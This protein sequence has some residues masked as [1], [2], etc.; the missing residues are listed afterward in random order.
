ML[1]SDL[2]ILAFI[3]ALETL[4]FLSLP[5]NVTIVIRFL[6]GKYAPVCE[7][8]TPL[9]PCR[10]LC[11]RAHSGCKGVITLFGL[12]W[13]EHL[14]CGGYPKNGGGA[15]CVLD[16]PFEAE[17]KDFSGKHHFVQILCSLENQS[18]SKNMRDVILRF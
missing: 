17:G 4:L 3:F 6:C 18:N 9:P 11:I 1:V 10:E 8:D 12:S 16:Q 2:V 5:G 7:K 15:A 14:A 13:P